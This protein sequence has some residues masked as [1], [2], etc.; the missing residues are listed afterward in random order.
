[1]RELCAIIADPS[2]TLMNR[3]AVL[4]A[5]AHIVNQEE[6]EAFIQVESFAGIKPSRSVTSI[7]SQLCRG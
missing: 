6:G 5:V 3:R 1:M 4:W 2:E 7:S